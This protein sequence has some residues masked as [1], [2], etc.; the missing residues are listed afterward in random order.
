MF[1]FKDILLTLVQ[2]IVDLNIY[3]YYSKKLK[4]NSSPLLPFFIASSVHFFQHVLQPT[5]IGKKREWNKEVKRGIFL[6]F[7]L[8]IF[9]W[10][11]VDVL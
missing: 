11:K 6:Y 4:K 2:W 10:N 1:D 9:R 3:K 7:I 8:L 5:C